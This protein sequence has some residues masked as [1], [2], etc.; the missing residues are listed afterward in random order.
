VLIVAHRGGNPDDIENSATAFI[1][2]INVGSDVIE[3]DLQ[4]SADGDIVIYHNT[5]YF[6]APISSFTTDELRGLIPTLLNIDELLELIDAFDAPARL[7]LDLKDRN[8][9]RALMPYLRDGALRGRVLI[10]STY[11]FGLWRLKRRF[12]GL[13]TGLSRGATLTRVRPRL[14]PRFAAI[15]GPLLLTVMLAQM[16]MMGIQTA[17]LQHDLLTARSVGAIRR[18]GY[19]LYAWTIDDPERALE[20]RSYGIDYLTTNVPAS[21]VAVLP[22]RQD[23]G[24]VP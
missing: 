2:G 19:R 23:G 5:R 24:S 1:H 21:M 8:V 14:R 16:K 4:L 18:R 12:P 10:T 9:D 15:V 17:V 20:L 6:R 7:V 22:A 11:S 3:C 13:R